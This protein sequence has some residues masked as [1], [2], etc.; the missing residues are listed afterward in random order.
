MLAAIFAASGLTTLLK[1]QGVLWKNP[2]KG[3]KHSNMADLGE[4]LHMKQD[5]AFGINLKDNE[6]HLFHS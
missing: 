4:I 1:E 2:K 5:I 3:S 6:H